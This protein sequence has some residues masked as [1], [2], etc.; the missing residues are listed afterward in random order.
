[1]FLYY[2]CPRCGMQCE[3]DLT[4]EPALQHRCETCHTVLPLP[5]LIDIALMEGKMDR[6][7]VV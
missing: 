4:N 2:N 5:D 3:A 7:T 6:L 1:M